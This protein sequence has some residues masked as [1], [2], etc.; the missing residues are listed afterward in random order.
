MKFK[1]KTTPPPNK[2]SE[3]VFGCQ[4]PVWVEPSFTMAAPRPHRTEA[5]EADKNVPHDK[6]KAPD[7][8]NQGCVRTCVCVCGGAEICDVEV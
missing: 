4:N 5:S 7:P 8:I 6:E 2:T 1:R 3:L